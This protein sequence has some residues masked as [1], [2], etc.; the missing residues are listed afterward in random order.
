ME[1]T[2][3]DGLTYQWHEKIEDLEGYIPGEY[4]PAHI[5]DLYSN[6]RYQIVHKLGFGSYATVWLARDLHMNRYMALKIVIAEASKDISESRILRHLQQKLPQQYQGSRKFITSLLDEFYIDDPNG[7]HLCLATEPARCSVAASKECGMKWM[8]PLEIARAI[9]AQSILG[10]QAIHGSGVI[11]GDLHVRNIL[12]TLPNIHTMSVNEIDERF[13]T[14][15]AAKVESLDGRPLGPE[16]PRYAV[17][18]AQLVI[19][20]DK[21]NDPRIRISDFGEAWL[22]NDQRKDDLQ[23]PIVFL[24]PEAIFAKDQLGFPADIWTLAC[25]IYEIMSERPLFEGFMLD[26]DDIV[27]EMISCLGPLPR[28]WWEAWKARGDFFTE[29]GSWRSDMTRVHDSKSRPLL[30]R[31]QENGR[32]SSIFS[33]GEV[34]C[35]EKLLR[36]M[37]EYDPL[38]RATI[39]QVV[40]S[41]WMERWGLPSLQT[42]DIYG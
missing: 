28:P 18:P 8:F 9:S 11:H 40:N 20:S 42:F 7:R 14:P 38:K 15:R 21:V 3:S 26:R 12:L 2:A 29:D 16:A 30:L 24:P 32:E 25:S 39:E 35:L 33:A 34:E 36:I 23:T 6:E 5:G 10:L 19:A 4:H 41:D 13:H 37:L 27:A 31:I 1:E 22:N 17:M